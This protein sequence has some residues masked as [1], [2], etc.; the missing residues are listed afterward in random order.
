M[1]HE[2][3][4]EKWWKRINHHTLP[5]DCILNGVFF[6][7]AKLDLLC[8]M[9]SCFG[10]LFI[11]IE[12]GLAIAVGEEFSLGR[13]PMYHIRTEQ[14][15]IQ[16]TSYYRIMSC[17]ILKEGYMEKN[18]TGNF[19]MPAFL[20]HRSCFW[21]LIHPSMHACRSGSCPGI[22]PDSLPSHCSFGESDKWRTKRCISV[23]ETKLLFK[24]LF[25][26]LQLD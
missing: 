14:G 22:V 3:A 25:L 8:W 21:Q 15:R 16:I 24:L 2:Q 19:I 23:S 10:T 26:L 7:V 12:I 17:I 20:L 11:S 9:A 13:C 5:L 18:S 4:H 6:Q 1:S